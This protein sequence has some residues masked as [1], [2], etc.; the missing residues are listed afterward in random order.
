MPRKY[1]WLLPHP[2]RELDKARAEGVLAF[3]LR[4]GGP[5]LV[6]FSQIQLKRLR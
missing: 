2:N 1:F 4:A 3:Q 6:Q 5:M